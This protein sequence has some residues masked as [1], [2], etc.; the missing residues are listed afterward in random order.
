MTGKTS[1]WKRKSSLSHWNNSRHSWSNL[2]LTVFFENKVSLW[3][4]S[5]MVCGVSLGIKSYGLPA[6]EVPLTRSQER[7]PKIKNEFT[8]T[9][10]GTFSRWTIS[11]TYNLE[12]R[13][14]AQQ[15]CFLSRTIPSLQKAYSPWSFNP[16]MILNWVIVTHQ[17]LER[18]EVEAF[19]IFSTQFSLQEWDMSTSRTSWMR[20][21]RNPPPSPK[22]IQTRLN[23]RDCGINNEHVIRAVTRESIE[24]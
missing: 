24:N 6:N 20:I 17:H 5:R 23:V 2:V 22:Y 4:R 21:N 7:Q 8:Q 14:N 18:H 9:F 15:L 13:W 19:S 12:P 10:S 1:T 3:K 16:W 11:E